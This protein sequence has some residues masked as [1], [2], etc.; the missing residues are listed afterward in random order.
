VNDIILPNTETVFSPDELQAMLEAEEGPPLPL[1]DDDAPAR[2]GKPGHNPTIGYGFNLRDSTVLAFVL[3]QI[4]YHGV[5]VFAGAKNY[6]LDVQ[7]VVETTEDI[8]AEY[9]SASYQTIG[10]LQNEL[11]TVL[12]GYLGLTA[13][14]SARLNIFELAPD[15]SRDVLSKLIQG[16]SVGPYA[17][18]PIYTRLSNYLTEHGLSAA[19]VPPDNTAEALALASLFYNNPALIGPNLINALSEGNSAQ[20]WYQIRYQTDANDPNGGIEKRRYYESQPNHCITAADF[21]QAA[22]CR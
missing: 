9:P 21:P 13:E 16:Y 5:S 2:D 8:I 10:S 7:E 6:G 19:D 22:T 11:N 4:K 1:Y 15:Q 12:G 20:V 3:D 17:E 18:A 14:Q